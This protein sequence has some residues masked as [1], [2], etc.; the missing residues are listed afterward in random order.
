MT[1]VQ[2]LDH[3]AYI[4]NRPYRRMTHARIRKIAA[5]GWRGQMAVVHSPY[6]GCCRVE[7]WSTTLRRLCLELQADGLTSAQ[8]EVA[9]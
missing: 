8:I 1:R 6:R 7:P 4:A 9:S 3:A 2:Y 5:E